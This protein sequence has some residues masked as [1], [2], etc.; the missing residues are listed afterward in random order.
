[1]QPCLHRA[2]QQTDLMHTLPTHQ[3]SYDKRQHP[4]LFGKHAFASTL[5]SFLVSIYPRTCRIQH[6]PSQDPTAEGSASATSNVN[7]FMAALSSPCTC[8]DRHM[9][10]RSP[11]SLLLLLLSALAGMT[12]QSFE[13]AQAAAGKAARQARNGSQAGNGRQRR[14]V[15]KRVALCT[16]HAMESWCTQGVLSLLLFAF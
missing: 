7:F 4:K 13:A 16:R 2:H 11:S 5:Y 10:G 6:A 12:T 9:P 1:M 8:R 14:E 15:C 3:P